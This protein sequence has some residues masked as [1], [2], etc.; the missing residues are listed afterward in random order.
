MNEIHRGEILRLKR[1]S[2]V[3]ILFLL[4]DS[5]QPCA[6]QQHAHHRGQTWAKS[7]PFRGATKHREVNQS[8]CLLCAV[9]ASHLHTVQYKHTLVCKHAWWDTFKPECSSRLAAILYPVWV[10]SSLFPVVLVNSARCPPPLSPL[11]SPLT[12]LCNTAPSLFPFLCAQYTV[13][14]YILWFF[15]K[16]HKPNTEE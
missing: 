3:V 13:K 12:F 5:K 2:C 11:S 1:D 6:T 16:R 15:L 14:V 7:S 9:C 8:S 10:A 4:S